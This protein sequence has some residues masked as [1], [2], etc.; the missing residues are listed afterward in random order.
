MLLYLKIL[1]SVQIRVN[2]WLKAFF[3][4]NVQQQMNEI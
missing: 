1:K 2:P 3:L 4:K